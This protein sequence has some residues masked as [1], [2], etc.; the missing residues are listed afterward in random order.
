[1]RECVKAGAVAPSK[2]SRSPSQRR[3]VHL[4]HVLHAFPSF[5]HSLLHHLYPK[6]N[7][8]IRSVL[9]RPG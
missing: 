6:V 1:M 2:F 9:T 8:K 5:P 7:K 3:G 4:L